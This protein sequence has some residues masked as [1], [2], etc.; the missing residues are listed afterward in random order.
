[1]TQTIMVNVPDSVYQQLERTAR[2]TNQPLETVI[3]AALRASLPPL[4]GLPPDLTRDLTELEQ[5]PNDALQ[6]VLLETVPP[7]HQDEL[8]LLLLQQQSG[9]L[10]APEQERLTNLQQ[11]A[12]RTM[13]RKARAA[14]LLR[15][16]G[17][18]LPTLAELQ[19]VAAAE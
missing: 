8:E 19:Q 16:R 3:L 12:D 6:R 13:L 7:V 9:P 4:E 11:Q 17:Q 5:L 15:F 1:M 18:R 2:A 10:A 14:A